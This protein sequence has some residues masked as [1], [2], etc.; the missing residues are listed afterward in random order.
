MKIIKAD[1]EG[2]RAAAATIRNGGVVI[3]PT[4]TV[5][6][7]GCLPSDPDASK[8]I[9]EIKGRAENPLPLIC[10]DIEM[11][12]K[13]G[14]FNI[15][16]EKLAKAFW[17]GP[18]MFILPSKVVY[19]MWVS[20]GKKT[21]GLRVTGAEVS[22]KLAELA[23]GVIVSTSANK[24]GEPPAT[25]AKDALSKTGFKVDL[26]LDGGPSPGGQSSTIIDLSGKEMWILRSGPIS[27]T[28]IMEALKR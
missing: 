11:A 3:Y 12:R 24:S 19:P 1:E 17:P 27:G 20:H 15:T 7:I 5:Y 23:G 25:T 6:G 26:V 16:A 4:E 10:G 14:Q 28:Q 9:C 21:I 18:L 13:I 22:R 2:L 8:R